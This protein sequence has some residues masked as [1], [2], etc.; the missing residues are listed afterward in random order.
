MQKSRG[1]TLIE[2]IVVLVILGIL[3]AFAVPRFVDLQE[4]ARTASLKGLKGSV[5]GAASLAHGKALANST[6]SADDSIQVQGKT[7]TM[8]GKWPT[9]DVDGIES[10]LQDT[11]GFNSTSTGTC[12]NATLAA[13]DCIQFYPTGVSDNSTCYVDYAINSTGSVDTPLFDM[14]SSDCS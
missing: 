14:D 9:A 1:F 4:E 6:H 10:M 3:G 12:Q 8:S 11:S 2:L 7:I 13:F 5:H